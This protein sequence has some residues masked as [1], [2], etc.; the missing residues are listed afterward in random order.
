MTDAREQPSAADFLTNVLLELATE[1]AQSSA[2]DTWSDEYSRKSIRRV[3]EDGDG[4]F[5][6]PRERRVTLGDLRA[7]DDATLRRLGFRK[8][9]DDF[10]VIPIWMFHY[11]ADGETLTSIMGKTVKKGADEIDLDTRSGCTAWGF[12]K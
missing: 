5:R 6:K 7:M 1:A 4:H 11:I 9:D 10:W 8:C 2:W 12:G 3:W